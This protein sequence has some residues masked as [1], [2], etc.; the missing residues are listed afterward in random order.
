METKKYILFVIFVGTQNVLY[1]LKFISS[2]NSL[3]PL[4]LKR[5]NIRSVSVASNNT[6]VNR[7]WI[8]VIYEDLVH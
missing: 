8:V 3:I 6:N 2:L 5:S 4:G 7:S 1:C